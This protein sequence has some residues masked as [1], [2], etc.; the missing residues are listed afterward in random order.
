MTE[1][2]AET[3]K[4]RRWISI[5]ETVGILALII[6]G[7]SLWD[8]HQERVETRA[9]ATQPKPAARVAPL[10]LTAHADAAGDVLSLASPNPDR[11]I[12]T[13]TIVFPKALD[14]ASVDTIGNPRVEAGWFAGALRGAVGDDRKKGRLPIGVITRYTDNGVDREDVSLYDVGHG[15]RSR[16]LQHDVPVLEGITLVARGPKDLQARLDA[17]WTK[18][19]PAAA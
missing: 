1:T 11:V 18:L 10:V 19:H 6:S 16:L 3:A 13:Q 5:G 17:R 2:P 12:Q 8:S 4:R 7:V 14:L 9:A 15:W